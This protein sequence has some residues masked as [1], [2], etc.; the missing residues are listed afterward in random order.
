MALLTPYLSAPRYSNPITCELIFKQKLFRT[1]LISYSGDV[2][3]S[4]LN[5]T[6]LGF[7]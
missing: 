7:N 3:F 4:L 2:L 6:A 1:D 5:S